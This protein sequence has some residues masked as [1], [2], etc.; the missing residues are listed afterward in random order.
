MGIAPWGALGGGNFK[1][2]EQWKSDDR[3]KMGG[4]GASETDLKVSKVLEKIASGHNTIITSVV[5]L[6]MSLQ[7]ITE[8]RH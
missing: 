8:T 3:R 1:T 7:G 5:C 6:F 2:E 4:M